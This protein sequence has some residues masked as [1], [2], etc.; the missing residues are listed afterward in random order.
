[1]SMHSAVRLSTRATAR[2][3]DQITT[4]LYNAR[5]PMLIWDLKEWLRTS[6]SFLD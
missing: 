5:E 2:P 6:S 4:Q 1:M 3:I